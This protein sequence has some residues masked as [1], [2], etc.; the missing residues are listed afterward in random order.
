MNPMFPARL[1]SLSLAILSIAA[2]SCA[3]QPGPQPAAQQPLSQQPLAPPRPQARPPFGPPMRSPEV[4][5]DGRVTFRLR[6]PGAQEVVLNRDGA[7]PVAMTKDEQGIWSVTTEP[8]TPDIYSY[9][10]RVDGL[11]LADPTNPLI[12]PS[13]AGGNQSLVHVPGPASLPWQRNDVP[14]GV[15][16]RHFFK[17]GIIGDQ[18]EF[19]VYTPPGYNPNSATRY[20]VLYLLHGMTD[21]ASA[22]T[23]AGRAHIILDNLIAQGKARP[24]LVVNPLGYGT[25]NPATDFGAVRD[26]A[27]RQKSADNFSASVLN[28]IIPQV[29]NAYRVIKDRQARAITGLS[30][31][32]A[33]SLSIGLNHPERFAWVGSFSGAFVMLGEPAKA[34]P[35]VDARIN[36][37][38]RL[39]WIA[40]GSEDFLLNSNRSY[41]DWLKKQGVQFTYVEP[42][43]GHTWMVW[44]RN[45]AEFA[46]LLF[47]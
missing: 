22:W 14:Q 16:H 6:A 15:I 36:G 13:V 35:A 23:T 17:S 46:P 21:D 7:P 38:T 1:T 30:M 25:P 20:P 24:M 4:Q 47:R 43:G 42:P 2:V 11:S 3:A 37:Q 8:L 41:R 19:Y 12:K 9:T 45:L 28:E 26:P 18:R 40:C 10:F 5:A 29:E 32:G 44:R 39:L 27:R 31:G 34:L 33:Q